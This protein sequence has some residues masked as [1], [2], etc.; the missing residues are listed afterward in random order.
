M[1][2]KISRSQYDEKVQD[3]KEAEEGLRYAK[4][5]LIAAQTR[6]INNKTQLFKIEVVDNCRKCEGTGTIENG[7][8]PAY[9]TPKIMSHCDCP[10]CE[11]KGYIE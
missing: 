5:R 11:G 3:M 4:R 8:D 2:T 6:F 7:W 10:D 9:D 1:K